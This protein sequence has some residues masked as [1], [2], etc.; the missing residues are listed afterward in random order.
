MSVQRVRGNSRAGPPIA[1]SSIMGRVYQRGRLGRNDMV[2][3]ARDT[4]MR[5]GEPTLA[6]AAPRI[7]PSG[8]R[9]AAY[10]RFA[11]VPRQKS[12]MGKNETLKFFVVSPWWRRWCSFRNRNTAVLWN[13]VSDGRW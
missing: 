8:P 6:A 2:P 1:V 4:R 9:S 13:H 3:R 7:A 11:S 12:A 10:S 5:G